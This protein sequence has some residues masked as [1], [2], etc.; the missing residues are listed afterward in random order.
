MLQAASEDSISA[1]S[2]ALRLQLPTHPILVPLN[3]QLS[4]V[5]LMAAGV[6]LSLADASHPL[7][8]ASVSD[9]GPL[10]VG[11]LRQLMHEAGLIASLATV[12]EP[13]SRNTVRDIGR[14]ICL[15]VST[16]ISRLVAVQSALPKE[17]LEVVLQHM[18]S[19]ALQPGCAKHL[20][21]TFWHLCRHEENR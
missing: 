17:D 20:A 15:L 12:T 14:D 10:Y 9:T 21:V 11:P 6:A 8:A 7:L 18:V 1:V 19:L 13:A 2:S 4:R 16:A 3:Q 5:H